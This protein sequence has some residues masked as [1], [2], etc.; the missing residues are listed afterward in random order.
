MNHTKTLTLAVMLFLGTIAP[1]LYAH[2]G[3][4]HGDTKAEAKTAN[5]TE[6]WTLG[7]VRK[8]DVAQKRITL[9]HEAIV[10]LGMDPMTMV[11]RVKEAKLLEGLKPGTQVRFKA[12]DINGVL[13]AVD[14][15]QG[16]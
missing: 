5:P 11:F 8:V 7:E 2:N 9:K 16:N 3:H 15:Q 4:D 12:A 13:Y 10:N 6:S 1:P 14:V